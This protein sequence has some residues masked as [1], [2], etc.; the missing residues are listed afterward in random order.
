VSAVAWRQ[1]GRILLKDFRDVHG[2]AMFGKRTFLVRHGRGVTCAV[3]ACC[4]TAGT[5]VILAAAP[6]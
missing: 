4:W 3:S 1:A 2:D 6:A 5:A